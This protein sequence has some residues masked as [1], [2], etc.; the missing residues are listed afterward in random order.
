MRFYEGYV[1]VYGSHVHCCHCEVM[2][3]I[4]LFTFVDRVEGKVNLSGKRLYLIE[5]V[6]SRHMTGKQRERI[7]EKLQ[8]MK[9]HSL[10]HS[11]QSSLRA[12]TGQKF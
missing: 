5:C 9:P 10:H 8:L 4:K 2:G 1:N 7:A 3:K 11:V 12:H 6:K